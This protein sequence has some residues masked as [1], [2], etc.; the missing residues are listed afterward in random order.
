M[1]CDLIS[2]VWLLFD[3][4]YIDGMAITGFY[5]RSEPVIVKVVFR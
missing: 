2:G 4:F 1:F 3:L 5:L